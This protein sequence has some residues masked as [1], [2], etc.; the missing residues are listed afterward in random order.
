MASLAPPITVA[1][2]G[3]IVVPISQI[4]DL[5][6]SK[7]AQ[8]DI[9]ALLS[10]LLSGTGPQQVR[11]GDLIT[12]DL[13]NWILAQLADLQ[14]R[15]AFLEGSIGQSGDVVITGLIPVDGNVKVGDTLQVQGKNF[16]Y[17]QG[18]VRVFVDRFAVGGFMTGTTDELLIFPVPTQ[19]NDVPATGRPAILTVSNNQSSKQAVLFLRP[20]MTLAGYFELNEVD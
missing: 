12:S 4:V 18:L 2:S 14:A 11:P 20:A 7:L 19:I 9:D 8:A 5:L 16:Q 15:V 10:A 1:K 13:V 6:K 3:D 17:S